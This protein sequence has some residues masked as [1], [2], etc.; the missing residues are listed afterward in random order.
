MSVT[1][2]STFIVIEFKVAGLSRADVFAENSGKSDCQRLGRFI[3]SSAESS[4][5]TQML[6]D[7]F[8]FMLIVIL[9]CFAAGSSEIASERTEKR[10]IEKMIRQR[11]GRTH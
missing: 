6:V 5:S 8:A 7:C 3:Q 10:R 1:R 2:S 4:G 9:G 11:Y